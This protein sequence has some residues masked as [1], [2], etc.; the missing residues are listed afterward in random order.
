MM[1]LDN[2]K[3]VNDQ[4]GH[5]MGDEVLITTAAILKNSI[6]ATDILARLGG[7]EFMLYLPFEGDSDFLDKKLEEIR[8]KMHRD[9][10]GTEGVV[11]VSSS[12]GVTFYD[13]DKNFNTL[14]E[15]ADKAL[16]QSKESGKNR[17]T[18]YEAKSDIG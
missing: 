14:Y 11:T 7:D 10:K 3:S 18:I 4:L 2:F 6:R 9:I 16:Y 15:Q 5:Q 17:I 12:I 1:D 8:I 13:K